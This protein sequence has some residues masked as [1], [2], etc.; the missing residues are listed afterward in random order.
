MEQRVENNLDDKAARKAR[1]SEELCHYIAGE[2]RRQ[3][4]L[5]R[6]QLG[7]LESLARL[8]SQRQSLLDNLAEYYARNP[9][10]DVAPGLLSLI[11]FFSDNNAGACTLSIERMARFFSR[12]DRSVTDGLS[13]LETSRNV[14]I[15]RRPERHPHA[16]AVGP[17]ELRRHS[18]PTDWIADLRAPDLM[19][20]PQRQTIET[21]NRGEDD[22]TTISN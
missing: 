6:E 18:R 21:G 1:F 16:H 5:T 10:A 15:E 8:Q 11:T 9:R 13:R 7:K 14:F 2:R 19:T 20:Q 17:Q 3:E 12:S 4:V 22:F